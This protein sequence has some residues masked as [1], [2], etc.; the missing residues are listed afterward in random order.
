MNRL[1]DD[2][3]LR[4]AAGRYWLLDMRQQGLDYQRPICLNE[5]GAYLW[6]LLRQGLDRDEIA[7]CLSVKYGIGLEEAR[8]DA[9][10]FFR[11][12]DW[13]SPR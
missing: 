13:S 11:M 1:A 4:Y 6:S 10:E 12:G 7:G 5:S 8:Q 2:F 3:Q 9:D